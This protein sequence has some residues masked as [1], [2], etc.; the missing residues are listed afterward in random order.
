MRLAQHDRPSLSQAARN[1]GVACGHVPIDDGPSGR[2]HAGHI[3]Q[4][5]QGDRN[6]VQG[7][8]AVAGEERVLCS[9]SCRHG[10]LRFDVEVGVERAVEAIDALEVRGLEVDALRI[11]AFP[12]SAAVNEFIHEHDQIFLVEKTTSLNFIFF[13]FLTKSKL[14]FLKKNFAL[15]R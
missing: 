9:A 8:N 2:R 12:F 3:D 10:T 7:A 6:A 5:L 15:L 4:V 11:R 14:L 13:N 1:C